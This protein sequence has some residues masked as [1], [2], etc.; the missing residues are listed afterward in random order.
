VVRYA[1]DWPNE[2]IKW[3]IIIVM[4]ISSLS[5][6]PMIYGSGATEGAHYEAE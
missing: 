1:I 6:L 5:L 2:M 4:M 3:G